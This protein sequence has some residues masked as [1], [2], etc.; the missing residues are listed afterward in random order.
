[1]EGTFIT[2]YLEWN[3]KSHG[4][5]CGLGHQCIKYPIH[6]LQKYDSM[7]RAMFFVQLHVYNY[8]GHFC[9]V[10]SIPVRLPS[11]F[12]PREGVVMDVYPDNQSPYLDTDV[13][14]NTTV[15]CFVWRGF[16]HHENV[17]L[18]AGLG[19]RRKSDDVV[20]FHNINEVGY[21]C[22][23]YNGTEYTK[24][25][26][27][28]KA[29]CSG[30]KTYI[31]SDGLTVLKKRDISSSLKVFH[32]SICNKENYIQMT[33]LNTEAKLHLSQRL[34]PGSTYSLTSPSNAS[35]SFTLINSNIY[36]KKWHFFT[37]KTIVTFIPLDS[38][39]QVNLKLNNNELNSTFNIDIKLCKYDPEMA[40]QSS[41]SLIPIHWSLPDKYAKYI[42]HYE[43]GICKMSSSDKSSCSD[44]MIFTLDGN[45]T[46]KYFQGHFN[47]GFYKAGVRSCFGHTCLEPVWSK[48]IKIKNTMTSPIIT[49][50]SGSTQLYCFNTNISLNRFQCTSGADRTFAVGYRWALFSD[51]RGQN[52][53]SDWKI[54]TNTTQLSTVQ[55]LF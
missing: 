7:L 5:Q 54:L 22:E 52:M 51:G 36:I 19:T 27:T 26:V 49:E 25:F 29:S 44:D 17:Q 43:T 55:V 11:L 28:I 46:T 24:Y 35:E 32:G 15:Y 31:S 16:G 38:I 14:F 48:G 18:M 50:A 20:K 4:G 23:E 37:T 53:I 33:K 1:M 39:S 2:P 34:T 10:N 3:I 21:L 13:T 42:S 40:V 45:E 12:P 41:N 9:S 47:D 8:A 6:R 30:G